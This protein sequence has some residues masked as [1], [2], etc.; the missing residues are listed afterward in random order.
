MTSKT[1][2]TA[3][4]ATGR[5]TRK[6]AAKVKDSARDLAGQVEGAPSRL[7][8][9]VPGALSMIESMPKAQRRKVASISF[10]VGAGLYFFGAPRILAFLALIPAIAVGGTQMARGL[11][12]R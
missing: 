5:R 12:R 6:K 10:A 2:K 4:S 9:M 8:H 1:T 7:A 3:K 11:G